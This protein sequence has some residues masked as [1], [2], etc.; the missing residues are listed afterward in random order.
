MRVLVVALLLMVRET[1]CRSFRYTALGDFGTGAYDAGQFQE[2]LNADAFHATSDELDSQFTLSVGDNIYVGNT[3]QG[4]KESFENMWAK[5]GAHHGGP[6]LMCVGNHDNVGTQIAYTKSNKDW[7]FPAAFFTKT[8]ETDLNFSVQVWSIN[9]H[10]F[11]GGQ[12][13]WL[14]SSLEKSTARWKIF[15]THY[16]WISS[17]RHKRVPSPVS[18]AQIA[19]KY[20]VQV[21]FNG[22]D[23]LVQSLVSEGVAFV[24]TGAVARG[25]ML[26]R[27][28]E[29]DKT[30]FLWA[31]GI[32]YH[33]GYHG[34]VHVALT[35]NVMWGMLYHHE[36][37]V[38]EF[39]TVHDYPMRY[40]DVGGEPKD[41]TFPPPDT[42]LKYLNLE[43][44][45]TKEPTTSGAEPATPRTP[46]TPTPTIGGN[47]T[48]ATK[49]DVKAENDKRLLATPSEIIET[50]AKSKLTYVVSTTC[51]KCRGPSVNRN[52]TLWV[53]GVTY[54]N[55]HRVFISYSAFDCTK[56]GAERGRVFGTGLYT[57]TTPVI[58]FRPVGEIPGGVA[59][60]PATVC[61]SEDNGE[62]FSTLLH[63]ATGLN[64]FELFATP[65][66]EENDEAELEASL[67]GDKVERKV[68]AKTRF[69]TLRSGS[70]GIPSSWFYILAAVAAMAI[71]LAWYVIL[72]TQ[73]NK[74]KIPK[75]QQ[76]ARKAECRR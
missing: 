4:I 51:R 59:S 29:K 28:I 52:S 11:D 73:H 10:S 17:G 71:P 27:N 34:I 39:T 58:T 6:W 23:H 5:P 57:P 61:F 8:F 31:F 63:A 37:L 18:V 26:N 49:E 12:M 74:N 30:D 35:H 68:R 24:G 32:G 62:T 72:K 45:T 3:Q 36:N 20:N 2:V 41:T 48:L 70:E 44:D 76:D 56:E 21:V 1:R 42:I 14:T 69:I 64:S 75:T 46:E 60:I 43:A 15:F 53:Q 38:H 9:T 47:T 13:N 33:V 67:K 22:H 66:A 40:K 54:T 7:V 16:P 55:A 19:K 50:K 65:S 25:A